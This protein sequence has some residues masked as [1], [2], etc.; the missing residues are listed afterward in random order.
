M[1]KI[2]YTR[3]ERITIF[4]LLFWAIIFSAFLPFTN[5]SNKEVS[6]MRLANTIY[7]LFIMSMISAGVRATKSGFILQS[8]TD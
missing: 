2:I 7:V 6:S 1:L 4:I 3:F 8:D 5:I